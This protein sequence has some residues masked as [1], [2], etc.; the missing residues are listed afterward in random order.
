MDIVTLN[1][2]I[3]IS[4][5]LSVLFVEDEENLRQEMSEV[6]DDIF[7][8]VTLAQDGKEGWE[9]YCSFYETYGRYPDIIISDIN[10][11]YLSGVEMSKKILSVNPEQMIVIL[12][13]YDET[14]Y[15]LELLNMGVD[16]YVLKPIDHKT[17]LET[18]QRASK[19]VMYR[20]MALKHTKEL[21][22][23]AYLD[24]LTGISNRRRFFK[25]T[26]GLLRDKIPH[27]PPFTLCMV[28]LDKFK[29]INDRYGH[30]MGDAVLC[31][32]V[33]IMQ[34]ELHAKECFV[35]FGGDEFIVIFQRNNH[36]IEEV[37]QRI[38]TA[39]ANTHE[40]LGEDIYFSVSM[41]WTEITVKDPNIEVAIK[42]ADLQL[43]EM[44]QA[45]KQRQIEYM[46]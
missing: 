34:K 46:I 21:E 8:S 36:E 37:L 40:L 39:I 20:N 16:A 38:N 22:S 14:K 19:K 31:H 28:D 3:P 18:L 27:L 26:N 23:M 15:V 5:E 35:R 9:K 4:R 24:P 45:K 10:M 41:G 32:F 7:E 1:S 12:S 33:E 43:Y 30:D 2:L 13:A 6:L 17:F 25:I 11:P 42:R 29:E 44:K